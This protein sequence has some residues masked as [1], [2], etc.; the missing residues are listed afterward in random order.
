MLQL[1]LKHDYYNL[2]TP[3]NRVLLEKLTSK[4]A[5][6]REIPRIYGT[7]KFLTVPT[8]AR[9]VS[10]SWANSIQPHDPLQLPED[11]S[12][13]PPIYVLVSLMAS[14]PQ[15]FPP[16][17]CA[18][19]Y[20]PPYAPHALSIWFV[21]ILPPSQYWARSTDHLLVMQLSPFPRHL[22]PLRPKYSHHPI[23]KH[24]QPAFLPQCQ[25]LGFTPIQ[26]H[27]QNYSSTYLDL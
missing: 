9:H 18:Q 2:L 25:R 10:L 4:L 20:P 19:L 21:S 1:H 7:R 24:P 23:L 5:A 11:P 8:S 12:K 6:S 22:V 26:N 3:W 27:G 17:P 14:F 16:T 15:A 13:Y